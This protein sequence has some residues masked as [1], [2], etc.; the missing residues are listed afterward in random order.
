MPPGLEAGSP[1]CPPNPAVYCFPDPPLIHVGTQTIDYI[2]Q[3]GLG[4]KVIYATP[5]I[6]VLFGRGE[7]TCSGVKSCKWFI[8]T[9][10]VYTVTSQYLSSQSWTKTRTTESVNA[11]F[12]ANT[13]EDGTTSSNYPPSSVCGPGWF[14][15]SE[16]TNFVIF[17]RVKIWD[18]LPEDGTFT[19]GNSDNGSDCEEKASCADGVFD[20]T[21]ACVSPQSELDCN[22]CWQPF[23]IVNNPT[24]FTI[25]ATEIRSA[26]GITGCDAEFCGTTIANCNSNFTTCP[27]VSQTLPCES[28]VF[29]GDITDYCDCT[30]Q[31]PSD[32]CPTSIPQFGTGLFVECGFFGL[33]P[34]PIFTSTY[35][36]CSG[37]DC[38]ATCCYIIGCEDCV[39]CVP[40]Y[41]PLTWAGG[42]VGSQEVSVSTTCSAYNDPPIPP[43]CI[44]Y[45]PITLTVDFT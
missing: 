15:C 7:F 10:V 28:V 29:Y 16:A 37:D 44:T 36:V 12:T 19:F 32:G 35:G 13:G 33:S 20:L 4:F 34:S 1:S 31:Q 3:D 5:L 41:I 14:M 39:Q 40:K 24:T 43:V 23:N 45:S 38:V 18:S 22:P 6:E 27:E 25:P 26:T 30:S 9:R 2:Y 42:L 21:E 11:C 17:E 8:K